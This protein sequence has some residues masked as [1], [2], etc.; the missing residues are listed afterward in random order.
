MTVLNILKVP[1]KILKTPTSEVTD[2][3][4]VEDIVKDMMETA[5]ANNLLG[6]AA[7]QVG[8]DK[9]I[10]V[11]R[12]ETKSLED[13]KVAT[14]FSPFVNPKIKINRER[15]ESWGWESCASVPNIQ[16]LIK[17][18]NEITVKALNPSGNEFE[19]DANGLLARII[20]HENAHLQAKL[21]V[22]Q[23]RE[24]RIVK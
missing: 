22:E 6:L 11:I 9:S 15:G 7:N 14:S 5:I 3:S 16:C 1:N 13:D 12:Y 23:A 10:F 18:W 20:Q 24:K 17:R 8:I 2:F 19:I 21:I 4:E